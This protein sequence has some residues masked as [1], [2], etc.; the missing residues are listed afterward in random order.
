MNLDQL[1]DSRLRHVGGLAQVP[2]A[3]AGGQ[4]PEALAGSPLDAAQEALG[5][6]LSATQHSHHMS[7][8][9][10]LL[11]VQNDNVRKVLEKL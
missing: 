4:I 11:D 2:G 9:S 8:A 3:A 7:L 10:A 1:Q 5:V 6:K